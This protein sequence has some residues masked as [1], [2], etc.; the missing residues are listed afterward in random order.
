M[1]DTRTQV[2]DLA[3]RGLRERGY[4]AVSFRDLADALGIRSASVHYHFRHKEDLGMAV[5]D[6]YAAGVAQQLGPAGALPWPRAVG[7]FCKI[8][9]DAL[10]KTDLQCLCGMLAAES[11]GLPPAIA[12]RVASY[13]AANINWLMA[14]MP[15]DMPDKRT[16]AQSIQAEIQGAMT[17]AI[18][19]GDMS[20]L[21][22]IARR[23][24][25][26]HAD[27]P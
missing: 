4:H 6:R 5:V 25:T 13:F 26:E 17:L 7:R 15:E 24:C 12:E 11:G 23:I 20:V 22:R 21:D 16:K 1:S 27:H 3:E 9:Q 19:L 14:C 8:Y 18:S 10:G 2:L